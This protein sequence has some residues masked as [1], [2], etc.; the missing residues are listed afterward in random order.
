MAHDAAMREKAKE[1]FVVNGFSM[2]TICTLMPEVARKTLYNWR[3]EDNWEE[4]RKARVTKIKGRREKLE[5]A[6]DELLEEFAVSK[7]PK[8]IFALGK[9]VAALKTTTTF[10]FTEEK[11][12]KEAK[13]LTDDTW[14]KI[15]E[16]F[17]L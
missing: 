12:S 17:G 3:E 6:L 5:A 8:L 13:E 7:N 1:M 2:D 14:N 4:E 10:K 16:R 9:I 11:E 15:D